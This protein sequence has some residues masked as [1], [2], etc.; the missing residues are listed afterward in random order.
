MQLRSAL[1]FSKTY[2]AHVDAFYAYLEEGPRKIFVDDARYHKRR[3]LDMLTLPL[4]GRVVE[5]GSDKPFI[6][7]AIR[8]SFPEVQLDTFSV[9]IPISPYPVT[10]LDME[11]ERFPLEDGAVDFVIFTEVLEHLFRDPAKVVSEMNRTLRVGGRLFLTTP[12]ACGYDV[13]QNII[14]QK[15]PNARNQFYHRIESGH[16]HLWTARECE[17]LLTA[18]GFEVDEIK[19]S[20]YYEI[21]KRMEVSMFLSLCALD[22]ELHGQTLRILATKRDSVAG[23]VYPKSL[24][25]DGG[26]VQLIGAMQ[27]WADSTI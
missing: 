15:T 8:T 12:N 10:P 26:P 5:A 14:E 7:H 27:R 4:R 2:E 13:L 22:P 3:Y 23:P 25:P 18:H 20:D 19:T 16:P 24:F 6:T 21:P 11:S 17:T 1:D 9:D